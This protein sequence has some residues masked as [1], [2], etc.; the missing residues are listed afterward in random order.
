MNRISFDKFAF[1]YDSKVIKK[2]LE[3]NKDENFELILSKYSGNCLFYFAN[4]IVGSAILNAAEQDVHEAMNE[5]IGEIIEISKKFQTFLNNAMA[6]AMEKYKI[7]KN[8]T[9][10]KLSDVPKLDAVQV[11]FFV[12]K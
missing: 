6:V 1:H 5:T 8:Y 10:F 12:N 4:T 2:E 9:T 11:P 7:D 3:A